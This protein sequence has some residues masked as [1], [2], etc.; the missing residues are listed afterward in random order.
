MVRE[1]DQSEFD[2]VIAGTGP[3]L[4]EFYATWCGSCRRMAPVLDAVAR[5]LAGQAEF[6]MVNVDEAPELVTRFDVRSTP[7]LQLFRAGAA[8]GAPLI[9]A[10]PEATVRAMVDT[11]LAATAPS[12]AQLLA[13]A[14]DAC[15]LPTAE[16]PFRL[17]EFADLFARSLR[18]VERPEPTRLLLDL[19][20]AADDRARDLAARE[21]SCC[22]FFTFTFSP[23]RGGVVR[24]Q[25]DVPMEQST[26]LDGL[27]LQAA[28]AA[29]LSR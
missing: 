3:V 14:P 27:A 29:G 23:P 20:E 5:E 24:M 12:S 8:V 21:T 26:V 25:V 18:E 9:G 16:R 28:T 7:T 1:I 4:V 19:E 6:I 10:Y 17:D 2:A 11:S 22:S 15:T 13:W